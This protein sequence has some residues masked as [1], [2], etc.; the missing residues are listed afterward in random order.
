MV[1]RCGV[2]CVFVV[3]NLVNLMVGVEMRATV[4]S[5]LFNQVLLHKIIDFEGCLGIKNTCASSN[6]S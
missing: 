5:D 2:Q 3:V 1:A 4:M 6:I